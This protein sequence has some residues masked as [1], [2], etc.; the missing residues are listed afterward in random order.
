M[1][2]SKSFSVGPD[3]EPIAVLTHPGATAVTTMCGAASNAS[4]R[5][6]A[7]SPALAAAYS[8]AP[9]RV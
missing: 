8:A 1:P 5:V 7:I 6:N 9:G 4:T 3:S 2:I